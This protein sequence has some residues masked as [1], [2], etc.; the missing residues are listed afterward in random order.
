MKFDPAI[1]R[2]PSRR[3]VLYAEKGMVATSAPLAAQ[4]GIAVLREGGNA[5]DAAVAAAA[6]L[7]VV[8]PTSNGI[9]GDAF[10]LVWINGKLHGLNASGPAP[11]KI[12]AAALRQMG[13][14]SM[15]KYGWAP[16]TVPG[17]PAAWAEL[18]AA[19]GRLSLKRTLQP[20]I[21]YA[22]Y[23]YP[24][25]VNVGRLWKKAYENY[26]K[27]LTEDIFKYWFETFSID[28]RC[29][30][31]GE[32]WS[33]EAHARTLEAIAATEAESFYR[34]ELAEKLVDFADKTG[35]YLSLAD[36]GAFYPQWVE[37][38]SV[39][40]RGYDVCE[41]PPNG[42]GV[43]ALMALNILRGFDFDA[44]EC[45]DTYHRQIEAMKL[46]FVDVIKYVSDPACMS[47]TVEELLSGSYAENRRRLIGERA[48]E[49][50]AGL[51]RERG[52]VYLAAADGEGN[53]VSYIQSNYMGFG[54][55][56]VVPGTGIALHNR[57]NN[58]ELDETHDN[59]IAPGKRPYHTIIP[60]F[61]MREG[62]AVGPF[63]VMGGFM[64]PQ[65]HLQVITNT[66]D[67][68]MNPQDC[69]DAPR[70]QWT[71]GRRIDIEHGVPLHIIQELDKRGHDLRICSDY[72]QMG[73][74]EIIWRT[75]NGMLCGA[76]E[77][78]TDGTVAVW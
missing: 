33:S 17:I 61:L 39:N 42:H 50:E 37:P 26:K 72:G 13:Y 21:D 71:G 20:A 1:Y 67:F 32:K 64:Q 7:T 3:N 28:G 59:V 34:G 25:A 76:A 78:R 6:C 46:A 68:G 69:L 60:G 43:S 63:G 47:V 31:I 23:G 19:F 66:V 74:G 4:A 36:L 48:V 55:G 65:G 38:I 77:P 73:R 40:Y 10:A 75:E 41:I 57:G 70:W 14:G 53:M 22:R 52:T 15:P 24:L 56:L 18:S 2:Y 8:E 51:P 12:S 44:R 54:S 16:V 62:K 30:E 29:P 49:P 5:V 45:V 9:G 27:V 35:G 11:G 58:F